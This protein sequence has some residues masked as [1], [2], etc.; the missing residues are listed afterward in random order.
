LDVRP[1]GTAIAFAHPPE[2]GLVSVIVPTYNRAAIL[3]R[4][5]DSALAQSYPHVEV[6]VIDDGSTDATAAVVAQYGDR[7]RYLRQANAGVGAA[8]NHGIANARGEFI[9][10]LDSDDAWDDWKLSAQ[11]AGFAAHSDVGI[12]W[13]D[14]KAI[15]DSG[16]V[17]HT[18]Y[19]REM[20][21][22]YRHTDVDAVLP[23]VN[24][25]G[26]LLPSIPGEL[27]SSPVRKGE[28]AMH[29]LLG[30]FLHTSTVV[31]RRNWIERAGGVDASWGNGG[32][33][34]EFYT[35]LCALGPVMLIDA[36]SILYQVGAE[37]QLTTS[38]A[39]ML[40]IARNDLRTIRARLAEPARRA[41]LEP[42]VAR[43]RLA[44][45]LGWVGSV[46]FDLGHRLEA[47][48]HLAASLGRRPGLDRR[49]WLLACCVLP[50]GA[51]ASLRSLRRVTGK[52][53]ARRPDSLRIPTS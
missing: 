14:M 46:E 36:P 26:S 4:A 1:N 2:A 53:R 39:R 6:L 19:L 24:A 22:C 23:A 41:S 43:H 33:D 10:F 20:Y 3:A 32:E 38:S 29:I 8:R 51:V 52:E 28:L 25:L 34:Y 18:R 31:V 35:R 40:S 5:L 13:T 27:A 45:A 50:S 15:D 16:S 11:M 9:A 42:R 49:S 30:N 48:R 12:V 21:L 47:A 7:V 37:D 44:R 17:Q